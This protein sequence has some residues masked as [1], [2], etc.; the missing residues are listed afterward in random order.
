MKFIL[1]YI[2]ILLLF[3]DRGIP[4]KLNTPPLA[5]LKKERSCEK[6]INSDISLKFREMNEPILCHFPNI[7][8]LIDVVKFQFKINLKFNPK[9]CMSMHFKRYTILL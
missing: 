4:K 9:P 6:Y 8:D 1:N 7:N 5:C 3:H 2:L